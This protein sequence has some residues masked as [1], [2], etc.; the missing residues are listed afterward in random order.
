MFFTLSKT[1]SYL[2][3]PFVIIWLLL[4]LSLAIRSSVW[5]KRLLWTGFILFTF[6]SNE[7][8]AN[9]VTHLWEVEPT[10][11]SEIKKHYEWAVILTGVTKSEF[12]P[13]D[14]VYFHRGADRVTHTVQLY[15]MGFVDKIL[16]SG[17]SGRLVKIE[18]KEAETVASALRLMGVPSED[19]ITE[20]N[21][22]NTHE[23]AVEV[24]KILALI[25]T[26]DKCILVTSGYHIRRAAACFKKEGFAMDTFATDFLSHKRSYT[27][28]VLFIPRVDSIVAW[29][30]LIKEWVGFV[31]YWISGYV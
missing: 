27:F 2:T 20:N 14:R 6:F 7:F 3:Q 12:D 30:A 10:P 29:N 16:V 4:V 13:Q 19:I 5:K 11:F 26:P 31:A 21:S 24:K 1:L 8:I 15:K 17:G 9:E 25:T 18:E 22:K 23:S 28:D